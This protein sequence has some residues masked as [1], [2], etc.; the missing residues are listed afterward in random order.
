MRYITPIILE[1]VLHLMF[2]Q[3]Q[4]KLC[5]FDQKL[6]LWETPPPDRDKIQTFSNY[7]KWK[8]PLKMTH[9]IIRTQMWRLPPID[10]YVVFFPKMWF[11]SPLSNV[12][13]GPSDLM[14]ER[15]D[16][17]SGACIF[18]S[19]NGQLLLVLMRNLILN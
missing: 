15:S 8:P 11:L 4:G 14:P 19:Y 1:N 5:F 6:G 13:V 18:K 3:F 2:G 7:L 10:F 16:F 12:H 17:R 9:Q